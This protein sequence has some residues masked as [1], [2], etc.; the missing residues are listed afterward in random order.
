MNEIGMFTNGLQTEVEVL[1]K[2]ISLIRQQKNDMI[3]KQIEQ[4]EELENK[5]KQYEI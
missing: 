3:Q 1:H 4:I 5:L 2:R